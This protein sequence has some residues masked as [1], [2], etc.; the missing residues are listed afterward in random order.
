M[1]RALQSSAGNEIRSSGTIEKAIQHDQGRLCDPEGEGQGDRTVRVEGQGEAIQ[2][3]E[4]MATSQRI[5]QI[6][7]A[8]VQAK[9]AQLMAKT[10]TAWAKE[11]DRT[12]VDGRGAPC[13]AV[14]RHRHVSDMPQMVARKERRANSC[15]SGTAPKPRNPRELRGFVWLRPRNSHSTY[16]PPSS[17]PSFPDELCIA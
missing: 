8:A 7:R 15:G 14:A 6:R 13:L 16:S 12:T 11:G 3:R 2:A 4:P 17:S 9:L 10:S 5:S 1:V